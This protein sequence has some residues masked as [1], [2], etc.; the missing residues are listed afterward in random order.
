LCLVGGHARAA[1]F[2]DELSGVAASGLVVL[3]AVAAIGL[4]RPAEPFASSGYCPRVSDSHAEVI[5]LSAR[6]G[7]GAA[8]GAALETVGSAIGYYKSRRW[9]CRWGQGG[10]RPVRIAGHIYYGGFCVSRPHGRET[11]FLGRRLR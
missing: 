9:Y 4:V 11:T 3:A 6:L 1:L 10:T 2:G 5:H 7:C 8:G